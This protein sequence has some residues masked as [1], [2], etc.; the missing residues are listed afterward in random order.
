MIRARDV[1][2]S[3]LLEV[4]RGM[5]VTHAARVMAGQ[6]V[7]SLIVTASGYPVG[8]LTETD[9]TKLIAA[10]KDPNVVRIE[11]IMSSPLF[12]TTPDV[13][14]VQIANSM[15]ANRIKKMPVMEHQR[16]IGM[17]TQTDIIKH[18]L[19]MSSNLT[20]QYSTERLPDGFEGIAAATS[21][22]YNSVKGSMDKTKHWH[23]R[24][25]TCGQRLMVEERNGKLDMNSCPHC[26][27]TLEYDQAPPI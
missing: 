4:E 5:N 17:I 2:S 11:E 16:V 12:S 19:R 20:A 26:G 7:G 18:V 13:D 6:H 25:S 10:G 24:C 9:I 15:A 14:I 21:E 3:S 27:G 1:M 23:M 22:L 8:I